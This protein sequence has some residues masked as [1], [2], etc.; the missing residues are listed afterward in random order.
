MRLPF[1][2]TAPQEQKKQIGQFLGL[3]T[4]MIINENEFADMENMSSDRFPAICTRRPR[5]EIMKTLSKPHGLYH[6]NGLCALSKVSTSYCT[7]FIAFC[8]PSRRTRTAGHSVA[9]W[10]A[11]RTAMPA[12]AQSSAAW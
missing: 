7:A 11:S 8:K 2:R 4:N 5:G 1:L 10:P 12:A 6:K 9:A 3:N